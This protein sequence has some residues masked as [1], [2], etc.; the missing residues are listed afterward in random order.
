MGSRIMR[1]SLRILFMLLRQVPELQI[2]RV[3]FVSTT[4]TG[5][6]KLYQLMCLYVGL[7]IR[8]RMYS[9]RPLNDAST[10]VVYTSGW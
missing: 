9:V 5:S 4:S 3:V 7:F 6:Q 10:S 2:A 8:P 1:L